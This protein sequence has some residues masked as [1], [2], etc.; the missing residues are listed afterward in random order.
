LRL[1]AKK[2]ESINVSSVYDL[3]GRGIYSCG[4]DGV[5]MQYRA[6]EELL[7]VQEIMSGVCGTVFRA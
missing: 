6:G 5:P 2:R 1:K 3:F 7:F 4:N